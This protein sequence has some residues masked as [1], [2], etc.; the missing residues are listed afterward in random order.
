[1]ELT[2]IHRQ[3]I[4]QAA[5]TEKVLV[6]TTKTFDAEVQEYVELL[7][8]EYLKA[9][10][11]GRFQ[12]QLLF[13]LKE[14]GVNAKKAN[15]KRLYFK[16]KGLNMKVEGDYSRGMAQFKSTTLGNQDFYLDLVKASDLTIRFEFQVHQGCLTLAVKNT[17][18]LLEWERRI[19]MDKIAKAQRYESLED[20]FAEVLDETEGAG[21]G[22]VVMILMLKN[23]GFRGSFFSLYTLNQQTVARII[24][25]L[26]PQS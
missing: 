14:L 7:L 13:C 11:M 12:D 10:G 26:I 23:L 18:E 16:E 1:L 22:L 5:Q 20:A 19:I 24:L 8:G 2:D 25:P 15:I 4:L 17:S 21:L 9:L 6:F 3:Q